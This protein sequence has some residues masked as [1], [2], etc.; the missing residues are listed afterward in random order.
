[1]N[2]VKR[3]DLKWEEL[4]FSYLKT[5]YNI[6]FT[7]K[8]GAWSKGAL[9]EEEYI[10]LHVAAPCLHYG[11]E[12]FEGLKAF[13]TK[14]GRIVVFRP[15]ANGRRLRKSCD[16]ISIP[17]IS[18]DMF[19]DAVRQVVSANIRFVPPYGTGASLYIRPVVIGTG[20]KV[21]LGPALEY[22][23]IILVTPVGPYYKDGFAPVRSLIVEEYDRAAPLG[24]GDC[25]VGGNY[26]A[27]LQ[28]DRLGKERGYPVVLYLDAKEKR[29]IDEFSTSNFI[30]I[31]GSSYVT[32]D[33][34]SI[35]HSITNE[36]LSVIASDFGM[37]VERRHVPVEEL[38]EL[39][40]VGAVGTAAVITPVCSI[41]YRD[42]EFV[43]GDGKTAG[44]V[45]TKLHDTLLGIQ[46]GEIEDRHGWLYEVS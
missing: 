31:K 1:M 11:Q 42:K 3:A 18:D 12:T 6:R 2:T 44:P 32:P 10:P 20:A 36:S 24:V 38:A 33:S 29:Y 19:L 4:S 27:S 41:T 7:W 26:A 28:G 39:D 8:D 43:F 22:T 17:Q 37:S 25:K 16:R 35:L 14:D 34:S 21:G 9:S 46:R 30:S 23:F 45:L 15:D 13:E 5:D 40:E